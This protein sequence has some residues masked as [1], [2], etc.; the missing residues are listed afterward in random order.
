MKKTV[1]IKRIAALRQR[2]LQMDPDTA[3]IIQ[4]ENRQYF[5]GFKAEDMLFTESSGSLL[6]NETQ[7]LLLTDSRY[8]SEAERD[9]V[10]FEVRILNQG[11]VEGLP[12]LIKRRKIC[13][14]GFEADYLAWGL[15]RQLTD[16]LKKF[17]PPIGLLPLD[18][19]AKKMREVKDS[20]EIKALENSADLISRLM[21][22]IVTFLEPG[23]TE[24]DVAWRI[25]NLAHEAGAEGL[26]FP[27]IVASGPNSALPHAVPTDRKL[28]KN[29][30]VIVDMGVRLDGYCSD[31][32]R[33]IF[34]EKAKPELEKIYGIVRKAQLEAMSEIRPGVSSD[35]PDSIARRIISDAGYGKYFGHALGHG[36]GLAVHEGPR[37][38][39]SNPT[40]LKKG[41][42]V[43]VEP[44]I[45]LPGV[46]GV[47]LEEMVVIE[48]DGLRILTK[49]SDFYDFL[50]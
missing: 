17:S 26:A 49:N 38:R 20:F 6:I 46:G 10:N 22:E 19:S 8:V 3:W 45:Y 28:E 40:K 34:L 44:G 50:F 16:K 30:P 48:E 21:D 14:L 39:K 18:D 2:L 43:T 25:E 31:I 4:P 5:S 33:T 7:C 37:L 36:V 47:R 42:V 29:E 13:N 15:H 12:E 35:F 24:K 23:L 11:L 32:T 41:M 1:F 27:S 9:A